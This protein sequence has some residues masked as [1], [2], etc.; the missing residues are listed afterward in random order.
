MKHLVNQHE[1]SAEGRASISIS[2]LRDRW[3][4]LWNALIEISQAILGL[5]LQ[6]ATSILPLN[7]CRVSLFSPGGINISKKLLR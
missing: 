6:R 3:S 5:D 4:L 1:L 7:V 2:R